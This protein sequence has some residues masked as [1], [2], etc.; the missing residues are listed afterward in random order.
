VLISH[1]FH[2]CKAPLARASHVKWRY[3]KYLSFSFFLAF[4]FLLSLLRRA[5]CIALCK[6]DTMVRNVTYA[7]KRTCSQLNRAQQ[8]RKKIDEKEL[9]T[10]SI[11]IR[12]DQ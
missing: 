12:K 10:V 1:H 8:T 4:S 6:C 9:K 3:T 7:R 5:Y 2:D 11:K